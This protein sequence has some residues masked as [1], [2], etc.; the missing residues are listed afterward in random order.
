MLAKLFQKIPFR[1]TG[2]ARYHPSWM[3]RLSDPG[4][5]QQ[6]LIIYLVLLVGY[7]AAVK[8]A[9]P[10]VKTDTDMWYHLN[11]GRFFWSTGN[12]PSTTFFSFMDPVREWINYFWGFQSAI[13]II[14]DV[15]GYQGLVVFRA[16]LFTTTVGLVLTFI[17]FERKVRERPALFLILAT[18]VVMILA[19]RSTAV[20]PHLISYPFIIL[21]IH[22]LQNRPRFTPILPFMTVIWVN[23]HGVEWVIGALICGAYLVDH[24]HSRWSQG[25]GLQGVDSRYVISVLGCALA[26]FLN[27]F[28][29]QVILTPFSH[30]QDIYLAINELLQVNPELFYSFKFSVTELSMQTS[31]TIFA[32]VEMLGAIFL[33]V[34]RKMRISHAIL[35]IGSAYLLTRGVRFL[36]E[37]TL[38]SL[39]LVHAVIMEYEFSLRRLRRLFITRLLLAGYFIAIPFVTLASN[40]GKYSNYPFDSSGLPIAIT[41]FLKQNNA[42]GNILAHPVDGGY[43]EWALNPE[44]LIYADMEFPPFRGFDLYTAIWWEKDSQV[45]GGI[46]D[47]YTIDFLAV[48]LINKNFP[49]NVADYSQYVPV[50]FDDSHV[51]YANRDT[52]ASLVDR[53]ALNGINPFNLLDEK[54]TDEHLV[55]ELKIFLKLNADSKR[56]NKVLT[57]TLFKLERYHEALEYAELFKS[58]YPLDPNSHYWVGNILENLDRCD[59]AVPHFKEA[60]RLSEN[61]FAT[62]V[63]K[64][65]GTCAYLRK[66][67]NKAYTW[68]SQSM[69]PYKEYEAP[70][71]MYQYA[72]ATAIVADKDKAIRLL[73]MLLW[74]LDPKEKT[75]R[76]EAEKFREDLIEKEIPD[77]GL[78]GWLRSLVN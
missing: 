41:D 67:F 20:R 19:E 52:Q 76:A 31:V 13:F 64:H 30:D 42:K 47:R 74:K 26:L 62:K 69:N 45:L 63:K 54:V 25:V 49:E 28:G 4:R 61:T 44:L 72:Y 36:W 78:L 34:R 12:V 7:L 53:F 37:W 5:V 70:E 6:L 46:L 16:L 38:L 24:I 39:P 14:H 1:G 17:F 3:V 57:M 40:F 73:D 29:I 60:I 59:E 8:L 43:L 50:F 32:V 75:L 9:T 71:D 66:D 23:M 68:F 35:A 65:L 51:L 2:E 10:I 58:L 33:L 11:G 27:P 48:G 15:F 21:F 18:V 55:E 77:A 22:I 56:V